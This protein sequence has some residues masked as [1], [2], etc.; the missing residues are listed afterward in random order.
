MID[1]EVMSG[2]Y[3]FLLLLSEWWQQEEEEVEGT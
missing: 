3:G 1:M 2:I